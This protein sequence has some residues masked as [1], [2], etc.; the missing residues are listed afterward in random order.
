VIFF[1]FLILLLITYVQ[2]FTSLDTSAK[3][4]HQIC[5]NP[6]LKLWPSGLQR[7]DG[8]EP[9]LHC[10]EAEKNW[11]YS[12]NGTFRRSSKSLELYPDAECDFQALYRPEG[13]DFSVKPGALIRKIK[14]GDL[15]PS[16]LGEVTCTSESGSYT[17]LLSG[18]APSYKVRN[19]P[20]ELP[21]GC[22]GLNVLMFGLDSVSRMGWIRTL[23]KTHEY[24]VHTLGGV[25]L[26]G[27]NIVGDGT[28]PALLGI[29]TGHLQSELPEARKGYPGAAPVDNYPW[30]WTQLREMGYVTQWGEDGAHVGTFQYRMKGFVNQPVDHSLRPFYLWWDKS[31]QG[32]HHDYCL[33]SLPRHI[34]MLNWVKD[35]FTTYVHQ[36]KFSFAFHSEFTHEQF[37]QARLLDNDILSMLQYLNDG[38]YL[39]KTLLILMSDHGPRFTATRSTDQGRYEERLPY[40]SFRFPPKFQ[41]QHPEAMMNL[42]ANAD[43]VTSPPDIHA[44]F[45]DI[46]GLDSHHESMQPRGISLLKEIPIDRTCRDASIDPH[47]CACL[48]WKEADPTIPAVQQAG[49]SLTKFINKL[50]EFDRELCHELELENVSSA[51]VSTPDDELLHSKSR[52]S[53]FFSNDIS[54][55]TDLLYLVTVDLSPSG[56][57]FEATIRHVQKYDSFVVSEVGLSRINVY[58]NDPHCIVDKH[59]HL[60]PY[61]YCRERWIP[62]DSP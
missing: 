32:R 52:S 8:V 24:L 17:N 42:R 53:S 60:R 27:Y 43:R 13:D 40:F 6:I 12:L 61:C 3:E 38:G 62:S 55:M 39:D 20:E 11:V 58:G 46:L 21:A 50:T 2:K 54:Q 49:S 33:G 16:D 35:F 10:N 25:V 45:L 7:Y 18:V 51:Y 57:Q 30:I 41:K 26:K 29:L 48:A 14:D 23:P 9:P 15:L 28:P 4:H 59:P 22:S 37:S 47:W 34:N 5:I 19:R 56:A 1:S 44:T 36:P 31:W